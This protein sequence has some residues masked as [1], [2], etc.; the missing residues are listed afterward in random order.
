MPNHEITPEKL[1]QNSEVKYTF[2][3]TIIKARLD[4]ALGNFV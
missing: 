2:M 1:F 3:A 4:E